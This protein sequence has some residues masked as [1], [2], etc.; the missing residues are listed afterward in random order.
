[1]TKTLA[2]V[3][4]GPVGLAAAAHALERGL[5]P[6]VL[7]QGPAAGHAIRHWAHVRMFSTWSLN[8]DAAAARLLAKA[9]WRHPDPDAHP[10]G[11]ELLRHYVEPLAAVR[12]IRHAIRTHAKVRSVGRLGLDKVKSAGRDER[13]FQ[14]EID[15]PE[16][17]YRLRADAVIDASGTWFQPNPAGTDGRAAPGEATNAPRIAYG[18]P[19]IA[20][21][22]RARYAGRKVAVLGG[23]HSAIGTLL[24]LDGIAAK[25]VWLYR[26]ADLG[27]AFGGGG[28]DKLAARGAL[29][30][31]IATRVRD[32]RIA[33]ETGFHLAGIEPGLRLRADDGRAVDADELIVATGFRPDLDMLR[34]VRLDLD[35]ALECPKALAPLIDPNVHSCGT[36]RPHG[37]KELAQPE[38]GLYLAGM[39]SYG[40]APTFLLA[41]GYEQVRSIV[42]ELA[43][44]REAAARVELALPETGVCAGPKPKIRVPALA[45]AQ[46]CCGGPAK[47]ADACCVADEIAKAE[48]EAG[49]GCGPA[50]I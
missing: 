36:V 22:A 19:E 32:G 49:C 48:G 2:I 42:A 28:A 8:I 18:M 35:P 1:M 50:P 4:A 33:V 30:T 44:D 26:G 20:G 46:G 25:I 41:T 27:K 31:E 37:A 43:G 3:G 21:A 45:E 14:L 29:G 9:G 13:P 34:E 16:G 47:S 10:T 12:E 7:E 38:T 39:K 5:V 15:G 17:A 6:I 24:D 23:G 40:R 11:G